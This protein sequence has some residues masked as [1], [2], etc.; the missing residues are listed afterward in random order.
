M[1]DDLVARLRHAWDERERQ[2]D[3]DEKVAQESAGAPWSTD[4]PGAV[5][6]SAAARA[7]NRAWRTLGHVAHVDHDADRDHIARHDPARVLTE[8]ERGR[9]DIAAKRHILD[10]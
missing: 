3:E 6:V 1:S 4:I 7:G 9:R 5:H 2:L 10:R 8:V